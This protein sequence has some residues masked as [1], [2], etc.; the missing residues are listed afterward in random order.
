MRIY[1]WIAVATFMIMFLSCV[2]WTAREIES[3]HL[4]QACAAKC[5]PLDG[6]LD[7]TTQHLRVVCRCVVP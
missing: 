7:F 4:A 5:Q 1:A 3:V 2:G 6:Q